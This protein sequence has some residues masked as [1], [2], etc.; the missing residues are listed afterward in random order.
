VESSLRA[1]ESSLRAVEAPRRAVEAPLRA[2]EAPLRAVEEIPPW[3]DITLKSLIY[4][5][6]RGKAMLCSKSR[7]KRVES[8]EIIK[9][10][11]FSLLS[12]CYSLRLE[13]P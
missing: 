12:T 11:P 3:M 13:G 7:E 6:L 1:V 5:N 9:M 8:R 10:F 4:I 2:V